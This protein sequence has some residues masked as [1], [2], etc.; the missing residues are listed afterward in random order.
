MDSCYYYR[1][2]KL[3]KGNLD[4]SVDCTYV[5][6]MH[7]SPREHQIYQHIMKAE[8]T[9]RVVFQYNFGYKKCDKKLRKNKPSVDL[10][11]AVKTIFKHAL[12]RGYKRILVLEDDCE[13]DERI[14]DPE[15]VEDLNTFFIEKNP[16][17]YNFG[18]AGPLLSPIDVVLDSK[19]QRLIFNNHAHATVYSENYMKTSDSRSFLFDAADMETNRYFSK[20]TYKFPLAYQKFTATENALESYPFLYT[21]TKYTIIEPS[22][23]DK[24]VQPGYD[25]IKKVS[26]YLAILSFVLCIVLIT[27]LIGKKM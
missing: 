6:I 11:D 4:P 5:L 2:Y 18:S 23:I 24:K 21:L 8:P 10:E 26:N 7:D 13:F 22:G 16:D 25:N 12:D 14:R 9:S 27:F 17:V 19:H 15:I 20:F 1:D 3:P